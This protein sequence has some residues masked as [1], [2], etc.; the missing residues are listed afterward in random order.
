MSSKL[1][2]IFIITLLVVFFEI[3][4]FVAL[5]TNHYGAQ[6][7]NE[8]C[9]GNRYGSASYGGGYYQAMCWNFQDNTKSFV[10]KTWT[11][12]GDSSADQSCKDYWKDSR[13]RCFCADF[14]ATTTTTPTYT[15]V[16]TYTQPV[17]PVYTQPV[18][19]PPVYT[20]PVVY[21][22][23]VYTQPVYT[24]PVYVP[25]VYTPPIVTTT[26]IQ[27]IRPV[28]NSGSDQTV[29]ENQF[30][31]L[32][33]SRSYDSDGQIVSYEWRE[34]EIL[35]SNSIS[36]SRVY[37]EG[38]H[39]ISLKVTDNRGATSIDSVMITVKPQQS[40][41]KIDVF[42][43][44]AS[45]SSINEGDDISVN[46]NVR[47]VDAPTG[48]HLVSVKMYID[49]EEK[50]SETLFLSKDQT[51]PVSFKFSTSGLSDG[52]HITKITASVDTV[53]DQETDNFEIEKQIEFVLIDDFEV[54]PSG[55]C[56]D[57]NEVFDISVRV[58]LKDK[59]KDR[60]RA[61]FFV[62]DDDN[63]FFYIGE[64]EK[65]LENDDSETFSTTYD[66]E[67]FDLIPGTHEVKVIVE[68]SGR[69]TEYTKI[70]LKDC[71]GIR[72]DRVDVL[73]VKPEHCLRVDN[74]WTY[75]KL[76]PE[77]LAEIKTRI[78]NCGR[79]TETGI[80]TSLEAFGRTN[81]ISPFSL[82]VD[83]KKDLA[84]TIE[85]PKNAEDEVKMKSSVV[86]R[87][88][89]D[90]LSKQFSVL[91]GIPFI[92]IKKE[93][94]VDICESE[95]IRFDVTN[96]G[97]VKDVFNLRV[98]GESA[99]WFIVV[100]QDVELKPKEKRTIEAYVD[101]PCDIR[102]DIYQFSVT[103]SGSPTYTAS[104]SLNARKI[105]SL[106]DWFWLTLLALF[107]LLLILAVIMFYNPRNNRK[108][109][110]GCMGPHGC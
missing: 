102:K 82:G 89:S 34:E 13:S 11:W 19:T 28:A 96:R 48:Q 24:A 60:I 106:P 104:S 46:G 39:A 75:D 68:N 26:T 73:G 10:G 23:P 84:F 49:G 4:P 93:Y 72:R 47:L 50:D 17:Q 80:S 65:V 79:S 15:P 92:E 66:Y 109:P 8:K 33:G 55:I 25:P 41:F 86:N 45:P 87:F 105:F 69:E 53:S 6:L 56:A 22:Q 101:V 63:N 35:L 59:E 37:S 27:N 16:P 29:F 62:E 91:D 78:S 76:K 108:R 97:E 83:Q 2:K 12:T 36:F 51:S 21:T 57:E 5:A 90:S 100:P 94:D 70:S 38:L 107:L 18:Y 52:V 71:G 44:D 42:D 20:A 61:M 85:V 1:I 95:R 9:S 30:V 88:S 81:F 58:G 43:A 40:T 77:G 64:D 99:E 98:S 67:A 3:L 103:A 14:R 32:D 110:E 54:T 31:V 74:L 7:C